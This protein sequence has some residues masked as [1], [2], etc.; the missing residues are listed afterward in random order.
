MF[1]VKKISPVSLERKSNKKIHIKWLK[2]DIGLCFEKSYFFKYK[3]SFYVKTMHSFIY[4]N[5]TILISKPVWFTREL[6]LFDDYN[7]LLCYMESA[8]QY[9][10]NEGLRV[11]SHSVMFCMAE[12]KWKRKKQ[13]WYFGLILLRGGKLN[14]VKNIYQNE[15]QKHYNITFFS[16]MS[17][18]YLEISG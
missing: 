9:S 7:N 18:I 2:A 6:Y 10:Q 3:M 14:Y 15:P 17:V 8:C 4:I 11:Q 1:A 16:N 5:D 13:W 12:Y